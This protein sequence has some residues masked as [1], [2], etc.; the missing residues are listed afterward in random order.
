MVA[1]A[2]ICQVHRAEIMQLQGA[3][4]EAIDEARRACAR[5]RGI[6]RRAAA[7][8]LY[9][10]AEVHRLKGE[11]AAAEEAYRGASQLGLE[12]QPGLALSAPRAG[13]PRRGGHR[14]P[15][16]RKHDG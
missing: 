15:S 6:D 7:A 1:F 2:G 8:A 9:Q 16:R 10:Q 11:F 4:P 12:P 13:T 5:S 14:H 3:W